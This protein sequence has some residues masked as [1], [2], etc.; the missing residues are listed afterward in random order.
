MLTLTPGAGGGVY[1]CDGAEKS[2][3]LATLKKETM[4][5]LVAREVGYNMWKAGRH[6]LKTTETE[7]N[8]FSA[9]PGES[10]DMTRTGGVMSYLLVMFPCHQ[11][12]LFPANRRAAAGGQGSAASGLFG[13]FMLCFLAK[14]TVY[15][16]LFKR[17]SCIHLQ[18]GT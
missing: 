16:F 15:N 7:T 17:R 4:D 2:P 12:T 3:C 11:F 5:E 18:I 1:P 13:C 14:K 10:K 6:L 9:G 8:E